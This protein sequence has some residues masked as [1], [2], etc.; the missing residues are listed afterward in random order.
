VAGRFPELDEIDVPARIS[1]N[2]TLS[3]MH[4]CPPGEIGAI[5]EYLLR[6]RGLH[7]SVKLNPTLLGRDRAREILNHTLGYHEVEIPDEAFEHDLELDDALELIDQLQTTADTLDLQ[8]GV[9]LTNTLEV[10]NH[11]RVF[12][13]REST[14]YLSGRP[15]HALTVNLAQVL[16]RRV[17]RPLMMSFSGGADATNTP[18]LLRCGM[19]TVTTC[20]DLLRP[21]GYLRLGQYLEHL[22]H[23]ISEAGADSLESFVRSGPSEIDSE[24]EAPTRALEI[25]A[26]SVLSDEAYRADTYDR[27]HTKTRR[28]LGLFDCIHAPC[29]DICDVDQRVPAYMRAVRDRNLAGASEITRADNPLASIL[30][31][32]CHHPCEP[33][34]LR[35]HMDQPLAIREI[36]RFITDHE[37]GETCEHARPN[38]SPPVAIIGGGPCGL[39]AATFLARGGRRVCVFEARESGGGMVS[40]TIPDYRAARHAVERDLDG[41]RA[42]GVELRYG[43]E[44]GTA[45]TLESLR[46]QGYGAIVVAVGARVG[47][48]LGL[49][50]E[51]ASGVH[52]GL[53]FLRSAR[54]GSPPDLGRKIGVIG[55]GD[56]AMDCARTALRLANGTVTVYYRRTRSEMPAQA[57]ELHDL[58][59]EGG[60]LVELA[61][62]KRLIVVEGAIRGLE[63]QRM[64]LGPPDGSGRRR[65]EEIDGGI[66]E[67][68]VDTVIIAIGQL[69]DLEVFAG[70]EVA[71]GRSGYLEVDPQTLQTSLPGV[72]AGGDIIGDGPASIVKA[73]GDGRRIAH[74]ILAE[75]AENRREKLTAWPKFDDTELLRRRSR[76]E[77]RVAIPHLPAG[78]RSGFDEVIRTLDPVAAAAEAARCL[79]CD[80]LCSTCD[81]VCPNRA[82]FTYAAEVRTIEL[83]LVGFSEGTPAV[84]GTTSFTTSQEPQVAVLSDACNECGNCVTFCPTTGRPWHDKPR[85][86][87]HRGDFEAENDNAFMLLQNGESLGIHARIRGGL[88]ELF[89]GPRILYSSPSVSLELAPRTLEVLKCDSSRSAPADNLYDPVELGNLITLLDAIPRSMPELPKF[90]AHGDW[91]LSERLKQKG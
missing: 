10:T 82:I 75:G 51:D 1:D 73:A 56:V 5:S 76:I 43:Q 17:P 26:Q 29:S 32:T 78:D 36:K 28:T 72:Y 53:A 67:E 80:Y 7:T 69:P 60:H 3:T 58:L 81:S 66:F 2:V 50:G 21:G 55:G 59:E 34:C 20:S 22:E 70:E 24:T 83:P 35:T 33:V 84:C 31:R 45:V 91:V 86:F 74:A 77:P 48:P 30:G 42:L 68:D 37:G 6:E 85:F 62:P 19:R 52:D 25:Y 64:R 65:P 18:R 4:G 90:N 44:V 87:L 12:D 14:M 46:Q 63:M 71:V 89:A 41:V 57:E 54:S 9:K 11:R 27:H 61:S 13:S 47:R 40:A 16:H 39:T 8:F 23:A 38:G 49:P 15:L 79:D 88:H